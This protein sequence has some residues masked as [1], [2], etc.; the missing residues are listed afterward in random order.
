MI[1]KRLKKRLKSIDSSIAEKIL[2]EADF[3]LISYLD[4]SNKKPNKISY[5][6]NSRIKAIEEKYGALN[7]VVNKG[8]FKKIEGQYPILAY[9]P[10]IRAFGKLGKTL[11]K[12]GIDYDDTELWEFQ[13]GFTYFNASEEILFASTGIPELY[14]EDNA[15]NKGNLGNSCMRYWDCSE[16]LA[17]YDDIEDVKL[18]YILKKDKVAC[19]TLIWFDKYYDE[20]Y[21]AS[22]EYHQAMLNGLKKQ[23][24]LPVEECHQEPIVPNNW[25][26]ND[27][28]DY[29]YLDTFRYLTHE[30]TLSQN[31]CSDW[32]LILEIG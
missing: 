11:K 28:E 15:L 9:Q 14:M 26:Y 5:L 30:N 7:S 20:I 16:R 4:F 3:S 29:P 32:R 25:I 22:D 18:A 13:K 1:S 8:H 27:N 21:A 24:F 6:V 17:F 2:E 31:S 19:R 23:D 12:L 10:V